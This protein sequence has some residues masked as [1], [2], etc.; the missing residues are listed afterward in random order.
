MT[1]KKNK[2][3]VSRRSTPW[4][5][6]ALLTPEESFLKESYLSTFDFR[7]P[8]ISE[9]DEAAFLN[10]YRPE[11]CPKCGSVHFK[12]NGFDQ[13]GIQKYKC[14]NPECNTVFTVITGTIFDDHKRPIADWIEFAI[15]IIHYESTNVTSRNNR[16]S[17]TTTALWLY[18]LFSVMEGYQKDI[19][20]RGT[21]QID[22]TYYSVEKKDLVIKEG[23]K[24]RGIS[25]NQMCIGVGCDTGGRYIFIYEGKGKPNI[26]KTRY[27]FEG[28]IKPGSVLIHDMEH[29]HK[30]L[31]D[32][33]KLDEKVYNS[34]ELKKLDDKHNPMNKVNKACAAV[35]RFLDSHSGFNRDNI[36]GYLDILAWIM[37]S[38]KNDLKKVQIFLNRTLR[39]RKIIRFRKHYKVKPSK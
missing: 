23:H 24:L 8:K 5:N 13:N 16:N 33:L 25:R 2:Y 7:H 29:S 26:S 4:D 21:V 38:P 14:S 3:T 9:T 12:K 36:Q 37:N 18:K 6:K 20:L 39:C 11:A 30:I 27:A 15:Q 35:Q 22:E 1:K 31:V 34:K 19:V 32:N 10:S 28:H 17:P